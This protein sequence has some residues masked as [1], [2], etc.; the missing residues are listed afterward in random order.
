MFEILLALTIILENYQVVLLIIGMVLA[1]A[2]ISAIS[3]RVGWLTRVK[4]CVG[5]EPTYGIKT[6]QWTCKQEKQRMDN[7]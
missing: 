1:I 3:Y 7:V 5:Y 4:Q 2:V 6:L